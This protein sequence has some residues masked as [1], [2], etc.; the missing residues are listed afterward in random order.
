MKTIKFLP[1][2]LLLLLSSSLFAQTETN[3]NP[4]IQDNFGV[5]L[6]LIGGWVH[7]EKVLKNEFTLNTSVGYAGGFMYSTAN[8]TEYLFTSII[9]F[10]PRYYY[11]FHK[12]EQKGKNVSYNSA[13]FLAMDLY[14]VPDWGSHSS[15]SD[16]KVNRSFSIIPKWGFRRNIAGRLG[17]EFAT[18]LGYSFNDIADNGLSFGLDIKFDLSIK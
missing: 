4:A 17:F 15:R 13:N 8:K 3:E 5:Q 14:F 18:G 1:L 16:A 6:G 11:N 7:Y 12:R 9:N 2:L 10:E